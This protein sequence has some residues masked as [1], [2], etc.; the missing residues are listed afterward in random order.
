VH[1]TTLYKDRV[2]L[3]VEICPLKPHDF[4]DSQTE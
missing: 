3:E 1:Y 2:V 4:A